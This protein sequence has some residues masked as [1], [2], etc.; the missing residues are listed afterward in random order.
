MESQG[1]SI[2]PQIKSI[3]EEL[4]TSIKYPLIVTEEVLREF[5]YSYAPDGADDDDRLSNK[6]C[7]IINK[8]KK[9]RYQFIKMDN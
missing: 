8:M 5:I 2:D 3:I 9:D 7:E 1:E 4:K 6:I